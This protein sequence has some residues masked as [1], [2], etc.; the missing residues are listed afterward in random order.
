MPRCQYCQKQ[1]KWK[2]TMEATVMM[3]IYSGVDCPYCGGKQY[4]T[5]RSHLKI[6]LA[7]LSIPLAILSQFLFNDL[8]WIALILILGAGVVNIILYPQLLTFSI[9]NERTL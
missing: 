3:D 4:I 5:K 7:R 8:A 1:W 2:E 6:S 9:R